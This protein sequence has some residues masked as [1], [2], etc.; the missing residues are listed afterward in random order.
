[1]IVSTNEYYVYALLDPRQNPARPFYVGKG[2]GS[3]KN[4]H[5]MKGEASA[6]GVR[7]QEIRSA[8]KE[9]IS[10]VMVSGLSDEQAYL[11]EA[12]LIGAFGT[13]RMGG[14]LT[15][16]VTPSGKRRS[17]HSHVT[18]PW[19]VEER[20]SVGREILCQAVLDLIEANAEGVSN[21]DVASI[22]ALRSEHLGGAKDYLS[23]S[24]LG[25]LLSRNA[26]QKVGSRYLPAP[27]DLSSS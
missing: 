20:S 12:Q 19:G 13:E 18:I 26:I 21:S 9:P 1:M 6:K 22:L 2:Q 8:G 23:Y 10:Q 27:K 16:Q 15:N 14:S 3:R 4:S 25:I 11:L 24:L 5:L 7:I 17:S